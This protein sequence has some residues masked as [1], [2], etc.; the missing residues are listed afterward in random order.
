MGLVSHLAGLLGWLC[1]GI[2]MYRS[3]AS[4]PEE[5]LFVLAIVLIVASDLVGIWL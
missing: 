5:G 1:L 2:W 4:V 3:H